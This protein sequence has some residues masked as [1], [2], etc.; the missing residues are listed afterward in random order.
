[1]ADGVQA[2]AIWVQ[3]DTKRIM[4]SELEKYDA[5]YL[6]PKDPEKAEQIIKRCKKP[7]YIVTN[8]FEDHYP[9]RYDSR[10]RV[11]DLI[12]KWS[13]DDRISGIVLDF[14][15][16]TDSKLDFRK[17]FWIE[18]AISYAKAVTSSAKKYK[19]LKFT[20]LPFPW[21]FWYGQNPFK[22]K[23]YGTIC[24][25]LYSKSVWWFRFQKFLF[26]KCEP[27]IDFWDNDSYTVEK[28][29]KLCKSC[30]LFRY[31]GSK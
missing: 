21:C 20:C 23:K 4:L 16:F 29:A 6:D 1:M 19:K 27:V 12:D 11:K 17:F 3:S 26:G 14:I 10:K 30:S 13:E 8:C 9:T 28:Q 15:R 31:G 2:K 24:P 7:V 5:V 18:D 22:M 25:M